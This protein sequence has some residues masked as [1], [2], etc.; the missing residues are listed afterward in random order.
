M[1]DLSGP[2]SIACPGLPSPALQSSQAWGRPARGAG[3]AGPGPGDPQSACTSLPL[4][5]RNLTDCD[6]Q[7]CE[8]DKSVALCFQQQRYNEKHRNYLN[9]YCQGTTPNCSIYEPPKN[10]SCGPASSPPPVLP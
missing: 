10:G 1:L 5:D 3:T 2:P 9:I 7:T 8:C 6:R 4:G